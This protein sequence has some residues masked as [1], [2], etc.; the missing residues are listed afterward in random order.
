MKSIK[1]W[2]MAAAMGAASSAT[3]EN[4]QFQDENVKNIC[5]YYWDTDLDG[6][7]SFEE[8]LQVKKLGSAFEN[9]QITCFDE[10]QYFN[11]LEEIGD[12]AFA[13]CAN[14]ESVTLPADIKSIGMCAF[15]GCAKLQEIN[16]PAAVETIG[17]AS[18]KYCVTLESVTL[19]SS[20]KNLGNN[21]FQYCTSVSKFNMGQ[22][23]EIGSRALAGCSALK[24]LYMPKSLTTIGEYAFERSGIVNL[25][26]SPNIEG[27][28]PYML[29]EMTDLTSIDLQYECRFIGENAFEGCT[30]LKSIT[31]PPYITSIGSK[32]F[33][34]CPLLKWVYATFTQSLPTLAEDAFMLN[35]EGKYVPTLYVMQ[36]YVENFTATA[37]WNN[38]YR[39][40]EYFEFN[41]AK[42]YTSFSVNWDADFSENSDLKVFTVVGCTDN[43]KIVLEELKDKYVPAYTGENNDNFH[44]VLLFGEAGK[45]YTCKLGKKGHNDP[46]TEIFSKE[47]LLIG[48]TNETYI[49]PETENALNY[50]LYD[51]TFK[52]FKN[53][54]FIKNGKAYLSLPKKI[55]DEVGLAKQEPLYLDCETTDIFVV[56]ENI[57]G[58][59]KYYTI[60]GVET[61][62][63][64][65]IYIHSGK[66]YLPHAE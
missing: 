7:L 46:K 45:D 11:G 52:S 27:I 49:E 62:R 44:G 17:N 22:V 26:L 12:W 14:L 41:F 35:S 31:L 20:V 55:A 58:E 43:K 36:G 37:V 51:N 48:C 65:G 9:K 34:R 53:A 32:A 24:N 54:G 29:A 42:Q 63:P 39:Y 18:F 50:I 2:M 4:I 8:A 33:N 19:P 28:T 56:H 38:F 5:V 6:E 10:L 59:D 60:D 13:E 61:D 15:Y 3:A 25:S 66:K 57:N 21:A 40:K 1:I 64:K 47:N 16:I 30:V 23:E